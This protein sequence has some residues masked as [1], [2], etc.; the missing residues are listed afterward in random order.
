MERFGIRIMV[1]FA[2]LVAIGLAAAQDA[3]PLPAFE[4][5]SV[6]QND[7]R[8]N[9]MWEIKNGNVSI[10][11]GILFSIIAWAYGVYPANQLSAPDWVHEA[12]VDIFAK[13]AGP[14]DT[15]Q[16]RLML[17]RLLAERYKLKTHMETRETAVLALMVGK[18]GPNLKASDSDGPWRRKY[19][20]EKLRETFT[21]ITMP[22]FVECIRGFYGKAGLLDRTG[23]TGRYDFVLEYR[24]LVDP[25]EKRVQAIIT[26]RPEAVKHVGLKFEAVKAPLDVIVVDHIERAP[27]EN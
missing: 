2:S 9:P 10:S 14:V 15:A 20:D 8:I 3:A 16:V 21:A 6:K 19:D 17:Q 1:G 12:G 4:V 26:A 22:E 5:A 23:L 7:A 18:N 25:T 13:S 27:T 24:S 11:G